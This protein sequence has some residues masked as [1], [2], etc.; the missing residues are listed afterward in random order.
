MPL[1]VEMIPRAIT[2]V[3]MKTT[4]ANMQSNMMPKR[5]LVRMSLMTVYS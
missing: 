1:W 4:D 5:G 2:S 3:A